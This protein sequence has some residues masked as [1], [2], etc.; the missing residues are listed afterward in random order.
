MPTERNEVNVFAATTQ[1]NGASCCVAGRPRYPRNGEKEILI[2]LKSRVE[3]EKRGVSECSIE[4]LRAETPDEFYALKSRPQDVVPDVDGHHE[5]N[6]VDDADNDD[7]DDDDDGQLNGL[8]LALGLGLVTASDDH[9]QQQQQQQQQQM[10][11]LQQHRQMQQK[12]LKFKREMHALALEG[13]DVA[14]GYCSCDEQ[15]T[16]STSS[17]TTSTST[18]SATSAA[19][20]SPT[21]LPMPLSNGIASGKA[22]RNGKGNVNGTG[23]GNGIVKLKATPTAAKRLKQQHHVRFS[24]EKNFSD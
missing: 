16:N 7:D 6:D 17:P 12:K 18:T 21:P 5:A 24:D 1:P 11:R 10:Q 22:Y 20:M 8:G 9:K 2:K 23:N 14:R 15:W 13:G 4:T 19:T 3:E